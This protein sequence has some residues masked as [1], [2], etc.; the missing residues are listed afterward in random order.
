[1]QSEKP[2]VS[3]QKRQSSN[4]VSPRSNQ[5]PLQARIQD[6]KHELSVL[7]KNLSNKNSPADQ[8]K[9]KKALKSLNKSD[10]GFQSLSGA[11]LSKKK[12]IPTVDQSKLKSKHFQVA[13]V[14]TK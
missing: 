12:Q 5:Q 11:D 4:Q 8:E 6:I 2:L 14:E 7:Y 13:R 9:L 1:M 10:S 3:Q